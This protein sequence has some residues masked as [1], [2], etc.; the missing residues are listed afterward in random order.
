MGACTVSLVL[1]A[2]VPLLNVLLSWRQYLDVIAFC[3]CVLS[4][5]DPVHVECRSRKQGQ[6]LWQVSWR[7]CRL[8]G[9]RGSLQAAGLELRRLPAPAAPAAAAG[10][11]DAAERDTPER[12]SSNLTALATVPYWHV[13]DEVAA[14][15]RVAA[16][17][18]VLQ[19]F[20]SYPVRT[21][22]LLVTNS[23]VQQVADLASEQLLRPKPSCSRR[24]SHGWCLTWEAIRALRERAGGS[25]CDLERHGVCGPLRFDYYIYAESDV[26]IPAA[27]FRFWRRHAD[28]LAERGY[29]LMPTR[30]EAGFG[31]P[32][33]LTDIIM[34]HGVL[35][36]TSVRWDAAGAP[37]L[38]ENSRDRAFLQPMN[39]GAGS[40]L[41]SRG[42]FAEYLAGRTWN[43]GRLQALDKHLVRE[44]AYTSPA[45]GLLGNAN[46]LITGG[47]W[48]KD[49]CLTH[50]R[51]AVTHHL[52]SGSV[53]F[54]CLASHQAFDALLT[55][56]V[57]G[58]V[59]CEH[60]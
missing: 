24:F 22:M 49:K 18:K 57:E 56:C 16:L 6:E 41:L 19:A 9:A 30:R 29:L 17:R 32:A 2:S 44:A 48:V 55:G 1:A 36:Y 26:E 3:F 4:R 58:R 10:E 40:W 42:Q 45:A 37:E 15:P 13:E 14:R 35:G 33:L 51:M 23:E 27:A 12:N 20:A 7:A 60:V 43:Y 11:A 8:L 25:G 50:P 34:E 21:H 39:P 28:R 47:P 5:I 59:P 46:V 53:L 54:Q 52:T 31:G 38:Y